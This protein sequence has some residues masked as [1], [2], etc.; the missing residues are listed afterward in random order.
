MRGTK[1]LGFKCEKASERTLTVSLKQRLYNF[2][3]G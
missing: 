3:S 2:C 1:L